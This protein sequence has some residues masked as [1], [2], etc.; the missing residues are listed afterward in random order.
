MG[1]DWAHIHRSRSFSALTPPLAVCSVLYGLGL[2]LVRA[3]RRRRSRRLP[4]FVVSVGNLTAGGSGK[5]PAVAML[6][7]WAHGEG[8]RVAVLSRGYGSRQ[9]HGV[10][11]VSDGSRIVSGLSG[12]GDEPLMLAGLL[13]GVPIFV[14]RDR[15]RA[16]EAARAETGAD[17]FVLDDG[18]QHWSLERDLDIVLLDAVEPVGNGHLLPWGPLREPVKALKRAHA[19]VLTRARADRSRSQPAE[20]ML[21]RFQEIPCF[22]STH[23]PSGVV[24]PERDETRPPSWLTGRPVTAFCGIGKPEAFRKTLNELGAEVKAFRPFPDHHPFTRKDAEGLLREY[25]KTAADALLTTEKDWMRVGPFLKGIAGAGFLRVELELLSRAEDFFGLLRDRAAGKG[26]RS[27]V[28]SPHW[29]RHGA[30]DV[31]EESR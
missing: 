14:C 10:T 7:R 6:A 18:F 15:Y 27:G 19:V 2:P 4:G 12:S 29:E 31:G 22:R 3:R 8:F 11:M 23:A 30:A 13:P 9:R 26:V 16:G 28:P 25:R 5:T 1:V 20:E 24:F 21:D 17:F